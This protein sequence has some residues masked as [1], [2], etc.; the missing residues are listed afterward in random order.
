[1]R[2]SRAPQTAFLLLLL[3][4]PA[5]LA[6]LGSTAPAT[7][8]LAAARSPGPSRPASQPAAE[9]PAESNDPAG[10]AAKDTAPSRVLFFYIAPRSTLEL[11]VHTVPPSSQA[12]LEHLRDAFHAAGCAG[13][14]MQ[15]QTVA[16]KHGATGSNLICTWPGAKDAGPPAAGTIVIAA[17]YEHDGQQG[18]GVLADWSGAALLPFLYSAIQGQPRENTFIFLESWTAHGAEAWLRSLSKEQRRRI[19]AMIDVDGL[20]LGPA[21]YFTTFSF[22]ETTP[23]AALHLQTE[24]LWAAVDDGLTTPPE[25]T[26]PHHWLSQDSTDPF[27]AKMIPTIVIHSVPPSS[28]HVPGSAADTASAVDGNA[29]FQSYRLLCTYLASLDR[30]ARKLALDDPVW[31]LPHYQIP[32]APEENPRVTFRSF[33]GV[34]KH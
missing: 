23:A 4:A 1:M 8:Q 29:Y 24:L 20:G 30:M 7:A 9:S 27:R 28:V 31:N 2:L 15:E 34:M 10:P 13:D 18:Q 26:S 14:R 17:H 19:R 33:G 22:M 5:L 32:V 25:E 11:E 3:A 21:R 6:Q 16:D 12:R